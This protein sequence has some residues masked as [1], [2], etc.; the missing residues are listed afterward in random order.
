MSLSSYH[1]VLML[2]A[3]HVIGNIAMLSEGRPGVDNMYF[4]KDGKDLAL[5]TIIKY[6]RAIQ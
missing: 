3:K 1:T 5:V 2:V 6:L 4:L